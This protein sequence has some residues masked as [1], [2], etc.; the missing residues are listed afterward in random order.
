MH[1]MKLLPVFLCLAL[2]TTLTSA[3]FAEDVFDPN[4]HGAKYPAS[5]TGT[6]TSRPTLRAYHLNGNAIVL[7]GRLDEAASSAPQDATG[8]LQIVSE[9]SAHPSE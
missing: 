7:D 8:F 2:L 3:A 1:E 4:G 5:A 6:L 9:R